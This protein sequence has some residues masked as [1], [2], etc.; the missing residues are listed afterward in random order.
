MNRHI[1]A[2]ISSPKPSLHKGD[3][4]LRVQG[5]RTEF[6]TREGIA[7]A[8]DGVSFEAK[9]YETVAI[10]GES[11][12]GK[13]VTSLSIMR[14]IL[15]P[16]G[17]VVA[18]TVWCN[19]RN[20]FELG[21]REIQHVRGNEISMIF[22]EPMT[23]LTPVLTIGRQL[24]ETIVEHQK[25]SLHEA[26]NRAVEMLRLVNIPEPEKRIK[27]YPHQ[28]SGGMCQRVMIAMALSC[29]PTVLM[30]DEPTTALDVTIQAQILDLMRKLQAD[31]GTAIIL[32][33]HDMGV[34]AE[35]ADRV[36]VMYA[37]RMVEES[38]VN[39]I[40]EKPKHPYT[41]GLL[42]AIP[43]LETLIGEE[44]RSRLRDI[45]GI[46]PSLTNLPPG[47]RFAPRC[48]LATAHCLLEYP[49]YEEKVPGQWAACWES[50]HIEK[51]YD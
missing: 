45:P 17:R 14:L 37:G 21:E 46:V 10:V 39:N 13:S 49:P 36:I 43:A 18:G 23:S 44:R 20:L 29:N 7:V 40:F 16:P 19:G 25:V 26:T 8:V 34:V 28:I 30:A 9:A 12:S 42:K 38:D 35:M 32:I 24:T 22:Q 3:L 6:R 47:C 11:G 33:T 1:D 50:E 48:E 4:L 51:F 27:Q 31:F 5:L 41:L 15:D 2:S